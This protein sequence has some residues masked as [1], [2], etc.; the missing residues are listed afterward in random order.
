MYSYYKNWDWEDAAGN[1]AAWL[2]VSGLAIAATIIWV[3]VSEIARIYYRRAFAPTATAT[4][5]WLAA[6]ALSLLWLASGLLLVNHGSSASGAYLAVWSLFVFVIVIE[7]ADYRE[8]QAD[9]Q[10][11]EEIN[12]DD[13]LTDWATA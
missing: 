11:A 5:L 3:L 12:L 8:R 13:V 2:V 4:I 6:G 1:F 7:A 9:V 10:G